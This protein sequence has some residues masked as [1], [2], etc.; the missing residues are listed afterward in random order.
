MVKIGKINRKFPT[1]V[2][3]NL[4]FNKYAATF[5][6]ATLLLIIGILIG[7]YLSNMKL[8]DIQE[9]EN[10]VQFDIMSLEIQNLLF[11]ENPCTTSVIPIE[12]KLVDTSTKISFM[13]DQLGKTNEEV[14]R[15]KKYYSLLEIRHFLLMQKRKDECSMNYNLILFFYSNKDD[16][17]SES[18]KQG[19]VLDSLRQKYGTDKVKVYS[20]DTDL[21]LFIVSDLSKYYNITNVP[22]II[23]NEKAFLGFHSKEDLENFIQKS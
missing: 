21:N 6:I 14:I 10:N 3:S 15:L 4:E 22:G 23:L 16:K 1:K 19:Y 17:I 8:S 7:N 2:K 13:E 20:L 5:A 9:M 18:Q 12:E 11:E